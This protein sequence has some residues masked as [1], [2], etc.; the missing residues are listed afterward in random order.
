MV[1]KMNIDIRYNIINN[2][3]DLTKENILDTIN[4]SVESKDELVLPGLGVILELV[5]KD[6]S[7]EEQE[8]FIKLLK[9]KMNH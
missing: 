8:K 4:S 2:L 9:I 6:L 1:K 5:W 3:K 7:K